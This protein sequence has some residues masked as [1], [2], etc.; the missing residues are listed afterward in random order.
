[1]KYKGYVGEV[2]FDE[3][4]K[5]FHGEVTGT[6]DVITFQAESAVDLIQAFHDSVDDYLEFCKERGDEPETPFSGHFVARIPPELH[7][8]VRIAADASGKSMNA[9]VT[10]LLEKGIDELDNSKT[11][12][13]V[14]VRKISPHHKKNSKTNKS[15][16][17]T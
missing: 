13:K 10:E 15:R 17:I 6:R 5:L 11:A 9:L 3:E 7:R 16:Q 4:A 1:M 12:Q 2:T 8:K 14:K